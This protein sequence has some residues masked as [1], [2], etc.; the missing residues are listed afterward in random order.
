M[1]S[2]IF[3]L[4]FS[5]AGESSFFECS[6]QFSDTINIPHQIATNITIKRQLYEELTIEELNK[7]ENLELRSFYLKIRSSKHVDLSSNKQ[8]ILSNL[9]GIQLNLM[10]DMER[11]LIIAL[12]PLDP[13]INIE[14]ALFYAYLML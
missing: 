6:Q 7:I 13:G 8:P 14:H 9:Y 1:L 4:Y 5:I 3:D 11:N 2:Y 10:S 12:Y